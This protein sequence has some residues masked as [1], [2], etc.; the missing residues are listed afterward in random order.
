[1]LV[2]PKKDWNTEEKTQSKYY[3]KALSP[4]WRSLSKNQF[5]QV[6]SCITAKEAWDT[7]M[8]QYEGTDSVRRAMIDM[9]AS[10][11]ETMTMGED[12]TIQAYSGHLSSVANEVV[13]LGK[14]YK[15]KK[16]GKKL[17][18]SLPKS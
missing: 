10:N 14:K 2:K 5:E 18:R 9:L 1:M 12:E 4:I 13:V 8:T 11:F 3:S 16:L 17:M 7:L 6:Q 15:S